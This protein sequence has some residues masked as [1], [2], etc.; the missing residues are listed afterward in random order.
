MT[1]DPQDKL[2]ELLADGWSEPAAAARVEHELR[3]II[4]EGL[5]TL[6]DAGRLHDVD[7]STF[8]AVAAP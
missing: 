8:W 1:F 5:L 4:G 7:P 2:Q 6:D 3:A